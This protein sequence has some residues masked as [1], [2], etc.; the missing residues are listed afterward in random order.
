MNITRI[1]RI[2]NATELENLAYRL[3]WN[4]NRQCCEC[5]TNFFK[6]S[7]NYMNYYE[8]ATI[9]LRKPKLKKLN[10]DTER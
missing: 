1:Y 9:L 3:Y 8:Q 7:I 4:D 10:N 2:P 6:H 5:S